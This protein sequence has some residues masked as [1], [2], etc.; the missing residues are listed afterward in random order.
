LSKEVAKVYEKYTSELAT[1][2]RTELKSL[3]PNFRM[4]CSH[5]KE[6]AKTGMV[7]ASLYEELTRDFIELSHADIMITYRDEEERP[8]LLGEFE[9]SGASPKTILGDVTSL[10]IAR[11]VHLRSLSRPFQ[12]DGSE[13][14]FVSAYVEANAEARA[15]RTQDIFLALQSPG[16]VGF[17]RVHFSQTSDL[18]E[19]V[20]S[21]VRKMKAVCQKKSGRVANA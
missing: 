10:L 7:R 12:L 1:L 11:Y 16:M 9:G 19:L 15:W 17:E 14:L 8:V 6:T 3:S 2:L 5:W 4:Y 13:D 18:D 20:L 21:T